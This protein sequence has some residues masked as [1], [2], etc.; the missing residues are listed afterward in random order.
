M[1]KENRKVGKKEQGK[2]P[3]PLG[4]AQVL[5]HCRGVVEAF[6]RPLGF[7]IIMTALTPGLAVGSGTVVTVAKALGR[8]L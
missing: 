4:A 8:F 6:G 3:F 5:A 7:I 2:S 1:S